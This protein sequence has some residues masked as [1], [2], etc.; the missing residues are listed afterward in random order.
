MKANKAIAVM[1]SALM[2]TGSFSGVHAANKVDQLLSSMTTTQKLAQ[3]IVIKVT[4]YN[5]QRFTGMNNEIKSLVSTYDFGGVMLDENNLE[6]TKQTLTLTK[7]FQEA[8]MSANQKIPMMIAVKNQ[9]GNESV[10][11]QGSA[12]PGS[13]AIGATHSTKTA[14]NAGKLMAEEL[15]AMGINANFAP[16]ANVSGSN[17]SFSDDPQIVSKMASALSKGLNSGNVATCITEFPGT[18]SES[19]TKV[20]NKSLSQLEQTDLVPY[21]T[22]ASSNVDMISLGNAT[23]PYVDSTK[24]ATSTSGY[25]YPAASFSSKIVTSLLRTS[26]KYTGV[27]AS[28]DLSSYT[29]MT[30]LMAC[31]NAINAGCDYLV[32]PITIDGSG[33]LNRMKS[34][35]VNLVAKVNSKDI[36]I[37]KVDASVRRILQMKQTRKILNYKADDLTLDHAQKTV[38]SKDHREREEAITAEGVTAVKNSKA[39]PL[40]IK[41]NGTILFLTPYSNEATAIDYAMKEMSGTVTKNVKY[42]T[43]IYN[44]STTEA[45]LTDKIKQADA[46]VVVS[47]VTQLSRL[48]ASQFQTSVVKKALSIAKANQKTSVAFSIAL[49]YDLSHLSDADAIVAVY[50]NKGMST[51][52][53]ETTLQAYGPNIVTG[54]KSIFG[55]YKI[56]GQLPVNVY[57]YSDTSY[58][59]TSQ[60]AYKRGT[61]L[62]INAVVKNQSTP[63]KSSE[64]Y[65]PAQQHYVDVAESKQS[66]ILVATVLFSVVFGLVFVLVILK[67]SA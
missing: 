29:S 51:F 58:S 67:L 26:Y 13:Q 20:V 56:S 50:G 49:P 46:V 37:N 31:R 27:I 25:V 1:T 48:T 66:K 65:T 57:T 22:L 3:M 59:L 7:S 53:G 24:I 9:G 17:S 16:N 54:V 15:S 41:E 30:A 63:Q 62:T 4:K 40:K 34:L 61:G 12:L 35:M 19:S 32:T 38:A 33:N 11:T 45:A 14:E 64:N 23:Y 36:D 21:K 52:K 60:I 44:A 42:T 10:L 6:D 2:I 28:D 47:E 5:N 55:A 39:L 43:M 18:G 8:A